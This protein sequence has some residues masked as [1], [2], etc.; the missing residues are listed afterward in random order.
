M[1]QE[2]IGR[3]QVSRRTFLRQSVAAGTALAFPWVVPA[4]VLGRDGAVS[5]SEQITLG[6]IGFGP[7]CQNDLAGMLAES[8]LRCLA[9]CDIQAGR[10]NSGKATVDSKYGNQDCATYR[11]FRELLARSDID[12]VLIATGDH[13]HAPASM[14]AA[15]AGKDIYS[16]KPCAMTIVECGTLADTMQRCGRVYQ[17]GTQRRSIGNFQMAIQLARSGKLGK[18]H[19]MHASIYRPRIR[20]D[21]L[22]AEPEPAKDVVDWDMWLGPSPWRPFNRQYVA[23][24]WRVH[25][26]FDSG[27]TLLDWGAHTIDLCQLANNA[28][29]TTPLTYEPSASNITAHYANG[30]KLILDYLDDPFGNRSPQYHTELGTCPVRFEGDE[31]WVETGDSGGIEVYPASLKEVVRHLTQQRSGIDPGSHVRNFL[32]CVK[33]RRAT[34]ANPSVMRH[35]HL[36]CYA[37]ATAWLLNRKITFDPV[38]AMYVNDDE[39]NRQRQRTYR[40]PWRA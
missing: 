38:S 2:T 8:D 36:A 12:A 19:T 17:A 22:P 10:R 29:D 21:W 13:W 16:E 18:I 20:Y 15:K 9:I 26:D 1:K 23:G 11:D 24:G 27:G 6:V 33:S 5:P 35:S 7:R 31:G 14:M 4:R 34:A 40:E 37:A 28:D 30:V 39:A 25:A 3:Q 32:N